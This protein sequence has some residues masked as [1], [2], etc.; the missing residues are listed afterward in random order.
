MNLTQPAAIAIP[1]LRVQAAC[2]KPG[3]KAS[4]HNAGAAVRSNWLLS[5]IVLN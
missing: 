5:S 3:A 2:Y 4:V 1:K